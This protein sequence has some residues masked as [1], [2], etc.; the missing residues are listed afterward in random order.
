MIADVGD[1]GFDLSG[2]TIVVIRDGR[3]RKVSKFSLMHLRRGEAMLY[4]A[5]ANEFEPVIGKKPGP[6]QHVVFEG[7]ILMVLAEFEEWSERPGEERYMFTAYRGPNRK[8]FFRDVTKKEHPEAVFPSAR[9]PPDVLKTADVIETRF[10]PTTGGMKCIEIGCTQRV[11]DTCTTCAR[12]LCREH[13][14]PC[15]IFGSLPMVLGY[16]QD[17]LEVLEIPLGT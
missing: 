2:D 4:D 13:D 12:P 8:D 11:I 6:N 17:C 9:V 10:G 16:C 3:R 14:I 7:E 1:V 5:A 15:Y